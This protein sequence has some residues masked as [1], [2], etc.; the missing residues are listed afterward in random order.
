[1][2]GKIAFIFLALALCISPVLHFVKRESLRE[3]ILLSRKIFGILS[4]IFFLKHGLEYFSAEYLYQ[5]QY[6]SEMSYVNYT[7]QNILSRSDAL[8][9]VVAGVLMFVL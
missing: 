9:G 4:F 5:T 7:I 8:S 1:M 6:H 3:W 2:Y